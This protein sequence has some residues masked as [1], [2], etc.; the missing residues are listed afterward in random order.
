MITKSLANR[1]GIEYQG[2]EIEDYSKQKVECEVSGV[3]LIQEGYIT[4][5]QY[6]AFFNP[7][8]A[9]YG[10]EASLNGER[11]IELVPEKPLDVFS[12]KPE[13]INYIKREMEDDR[14]GILSKDGVTLSWSWNPEVKANDVTLPFG[15]LP[16]EEQ[17]KAIDTLMGDKA[18]KYA[19]EVFTTDVLNYLV[20]EKYIGYTIDD[21]WDYELEEAVS[22]SLAF[23][24][25]T[26]GDYLSGSNYNLQA[27]VSSINR[28]LENSGIRPITK[29]DAENHLYGYLTYYR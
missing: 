25:E 16:Y 11:A 24:G 9:I 12:L 3:P 29:D 17:G 13:Y 21:L 1:L 2:D 20:S 15:C 22:G 7:G 14:S 5:S 6:R 27:D 19:C 26:L 28:E 8:V 18:Y 4:E 10:K 23:D